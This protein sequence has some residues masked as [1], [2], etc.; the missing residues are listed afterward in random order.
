MVKIRA[1][2][3]LRPPRERAAE[4]ASPPYDV[5]TRE[6]ADA[7]TATRP[8]S[9]MAVLRGADPPAAF[10]RLRADG[11]LRPD[12]APGLYLYRLVRNGRP[13]TGVVALS[14]LADYEAGRI[15]VHERTRPDKVRDRAGHMLALRA[16][17]GPLFVTH[18]DDETIA[19][20][21][22][23]ATAGPPDLFDFE[24]ENGVRH[25]GWRAPDPEALVAAFAALPCTYIADGHHR[26]AAS[27][28]AAREGGADT[29]LTVTFPAGELTVLPYH[30]VVKT[31][32]AGWQEGVP[33]EEAE[34]GDASGPGEV[35]IYADGAWHRHQLAG[36]G[37]DCARLQ[38][39]VLGP[40]F[41]IGDPRTDPTV[42]FVGGARG[43]G[44]LERLVDDGQAAVAFAMYPTRIGQVLDVADAGEVMPPK[45]TWF[46]PKL[47]SGLFV[48]AW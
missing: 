23:T 9:F 37:L 19:K 25:Q 15:K 1:F 43:T 7:L 36:E 20:L 47:K 44:Y 34:D 29:M 8:R 13:Q 46:E 31:A 41:G 16:H 2:P 38:D 21:A 5:V 28:A 24:D 42:D 3:A 4:V 45:S 48:H 12:D 39:H 11:D 18:R 22:T 27:A 35:R 17:P 6:E 14:T 32:P 40:V 26:A 10:A 33:M 30:R